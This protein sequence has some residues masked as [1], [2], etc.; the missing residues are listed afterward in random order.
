M[1][2]IVFVGDLHLS[3]RQIS[4]RVDDTTETCL[5]KLEWVLT[6]AMSKDADII[7]TG[8]MFTHTLFNNRT[9]YRIKKALRNFTNR[10]LMLRFFTCGGNHAGDIEDRNSDSVI[11]RELGQ[12][13]LDGYVKFLGGFDGEFLDYTFAGSELIRGYSAYSELNTDEAHHIIGLVCH[14]WIMDAFGD[15]L[16]VY[17]DD[18]KK[19][20]PNLRFIVAGHD[21][22]YYEP[23]YSRDGVYVVRPGSMMRTDSGK[24]S[25]RI[26]CVELFTLGDGLTNDSWEK[27]PISCARP[28]SEVFYSE[29]KQVDSESANALERFVRQMKDNSGALLDLNEAVKSQLEVVG[30][31]DRDFIR[32]DL[33]A[34]GF[35]V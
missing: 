25:D 4:T 28:Y 17:P 8:D 35:V 12:F 23:Y 15:S 34:N 29:K 19:I 18:M 31:E 1:R 32:Q 21:H 26:P 30:L 6:F 3:D 22:A 33:I 10:G 5:E 2:K 20:F 11:Y 14:H 13:C 24:S 9:R 7:S 16:V 27:I